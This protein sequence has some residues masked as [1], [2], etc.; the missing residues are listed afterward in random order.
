MKK[1]MKTNDKHG[2][3]RYLKA[4]MDSKN[5]HV[6]EDFISAQEQFH[7]HYMI[8][9]KTIPYSKDSYLSYQ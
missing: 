6:K 9:Y 8:T 3:S 7:I 1:I 5:I 4:N 2:F